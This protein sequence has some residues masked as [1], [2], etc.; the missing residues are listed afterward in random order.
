MLDKF[1]ASVLLELGTLLQHR[2]QVVR[3]NSCRLTLCRLTRCVNFFFKP[4]AY[5]IVKVL[6]QC[7]K[8]TKT[9]SRSYC[10][11]PRCVR[12][13][14]MCGEMFKKIEHLQYLEGGTIHLHSV[15]FK[16]YF[17]RGKP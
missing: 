17:T 16:I 8:N 15:D 13:Y 10:H 11:H 9:L 4:V 3:S 1:Q 7:H 12:Q 14:L 6:L 5:S 2:D